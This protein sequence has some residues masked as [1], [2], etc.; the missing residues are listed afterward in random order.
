MRAGN[1]CYLL[2]GWNCLPMDLEIRKAV[3]AAIKA[4]HVPDIMYAL[5]V[6]VTRRQ[7]IT[8][9]EPRKSPLSAPPTSLPPPCRPPRGL[10]AK[11]LAALWAADTPLTCCC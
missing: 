3:T 1:P 11:L 7:V 6:G 8:L 10:P 5:M 9:L 2:G 4:C